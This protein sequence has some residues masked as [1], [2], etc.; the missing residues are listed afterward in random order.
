MKKT[1]L[2]SRRRCMEISAEGKALV[3]DL[4]EV[5]YCHIDAGW[6]YVETAY[7]KKKLW[8]RSRDF[9]SYTAFAQRFIIVMDRTLRVEL[10]TLRSWED[11]FLFAHVCDME[12]FSSAYHDDEFNA[13][14]LPEIFHPAY[15]HP[16]FEDEGNSTRV[17]HIEICPSCR[18]ELPKS[19]FGY[20]RLKYNAPTY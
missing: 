19:I 17:K 16:L 13:G 8:A 11:K 10:R 12:A 6:W 1:E 4:K 2:V 20:M 18:K 9:G 14:L 3:K 7:L 15:R 5:G